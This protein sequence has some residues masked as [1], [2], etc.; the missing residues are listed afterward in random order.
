VIAPQEV[1]AGLAKRVS[2]NKASRVSAGR[3]PTNLA[4]QPV[5]D[6]GIQ[7]DEMRRHIQDRIGN[8][9]TL[10]VAVADPLDSQ[11]NYRF[12]LQIETLHRALA[13]EE[14]TPDAFY[15][16]WHRNSTRQYH[17][18]EPGVLLYRKTKITKC[19]RK[20]DVLLVYLVGELPTTGIHKAAFHA[21]VDEIIALGG[22]GPV[23]ERQIMVCAP[24]FPARL[25]R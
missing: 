19:H 3:A 17:R 24:T 6:P 23:G 13:S 20:P 22:A 14:Y 25:P 1:T 4:R 16:P 10:I 7:D 2:S 15:L 11:S 5:G 21:A 18:H 12:D 8:F 9:N